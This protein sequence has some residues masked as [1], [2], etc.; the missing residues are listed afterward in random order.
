M[1]RTIVVAA[2]SA[3]STRKL[4][5]RLAAADGSRP[6]QL[7]GARTMKTILTLAAAVIMASAQPHLRVPLLPEPDRKPAAD[8]ALRDAVGKT[9]KL[10]QYRGKVVLLDFWATWC[11]GCKQEIPWF[12]EFQRKFGTK[13]FAVVGV[14]LD[15]GGWDVLKPFLT[16]AHVPY[17]MLLGDD[18]TAQ[19]YGIQN[20]PDTFLIDRQ[21][22]VAAAY[23]AGLVDKDNVEPTLTRCFRSGSTADAQRSILKRISYMPPVD[24]TGA[25][26]GLLMYDVVFDPPETR[27]LA[28]AMRLGLPVLDGLRRSSD[29][30]PPFVRLDRFDRGLFAGAGGVNNDAAGS[31]REG[32]VGVG[33]GD[34]VHGAS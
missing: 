4:A 9:A 12:V 25:R 29:S 3:I 23:I 11:T 30:F 24:L 28:E 27:F 13:R 14:S 6:S 10:N 2:D 7:Y 21:G 32:R 34:A 16:K 17:R 20:M 15:E 33:E 18:S 19:R 22:R 5:G 1:E 31:Y 8:F 26:A